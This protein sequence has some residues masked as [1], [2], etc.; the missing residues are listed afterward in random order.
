MSKW[1]IPFHEVDDIIYGDDARRMDVYIIGLKDIGFKVGYYY[2][3]KCLL[4]TIPKV[5]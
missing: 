5:K 4:L 2:R 3:W 1:L